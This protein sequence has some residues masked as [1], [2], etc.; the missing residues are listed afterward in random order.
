MKKGLFFL[1][2]LLFGFAFSQSMEDLQ[3][4]WTGMMGK[5]EKGSFTFFPDGYVNVELKGVIIEGKKYTVVAGPNKGKTAHVKYSVDFSEKPFKFN[6]IGSYN[7]HNKE[8]KE[9][10]LG[11][12]IEFISKDEIRLFLD[13][14]NENPKSIDPLSENTVVMQKNI[15]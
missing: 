8:V 1:F 5:N 12:L 9:K 2:L 7:D 13:F 10:F 11:G 14:N 3:G 6:L 15:N 4:K